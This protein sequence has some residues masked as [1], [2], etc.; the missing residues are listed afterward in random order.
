M[1]D[2]GL[3]CRLLPCWIPSRYNRN[4]NTQTVR[5]RFL[6]SLSEAADAVVI[7]GHTHGGG[8]AQILDNL[9]VLPGEAEYGRPEIQRIIDVW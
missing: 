6:E 7:S 5:Q 9:Q 4:S 3:S 1:C 2:F 8:E